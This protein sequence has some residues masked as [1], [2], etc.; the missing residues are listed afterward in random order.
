MYAPQLQVTTLQQ[1]APHLAPIPSLAP[2][3]VVAPV[4]LT[5]PAPMPVHHQPLSPPPAPGEEH[6]GS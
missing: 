6:R 1:L 4:P 3:Q 2:G 5:P